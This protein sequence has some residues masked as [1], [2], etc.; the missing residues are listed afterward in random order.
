M[1]AQ[2]HPQGFQDK[3]RTSRSTS[4]TSRSTSRTTFELILTGFKGQNGRN[5]EN[6]K[7]TKCRLST[8]FGACRPC[9]KNRTVQEPSRKE[10]ADRLPTGVAVRCPSLRS[11]NKVCCRGAGGSFRRS[12]SWANYYWP[13]ITRFKWFNRRHF[14][15]FLDPQDDHKNRLKPP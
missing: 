6:Q 14:D 9:I 13:I 11:S 1:D 3:S 8:P 2:N 5:T 15:E 10:P 12:N 4:G 7:I